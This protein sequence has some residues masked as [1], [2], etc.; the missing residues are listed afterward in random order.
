MY[1]LFAAHFFWHP[2]VKCSLCLLQSD[3]AH[4]S[5]T[6]HPLKSGTLLSTELPHSLSETNRLC[7]ESH[8][9]IYIFSQSVF[10]ESLSLIIHEQACI[11]K[12][13]L[14][15]NNLI[16]KTRSI[17]SNRCQNVINTFLMRGKQL[18]IYRLPAVRV[19]MRQ[20]HL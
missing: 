12:H 19:C 20:K 7:S 5:T 13:I 10:S 14:L 9:F 4:P 6:C 15:W 16:C 8:I 11:I 18:N 17:N 3:I 1:I 2:P